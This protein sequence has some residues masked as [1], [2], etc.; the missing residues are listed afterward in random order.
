MCVNLEAGRDT[1]EGKDCVLEGGFL[2]VSQGIVAEAK[3]GQEEQSVANDQILLV[4]RDAVVG[5][6]LQKG[7]QRGREGR[8]QLALSGARDTAGGNDHPEA[9]V[10]NKGNAVNAGKLP[11]GG[12]TKRE[13]GKAH[14][15]Q[16]GIKGV[17][18]Q[19]HRDEKRRS[20]KSKV[21][22]IARGIPRHG[23]IGPPGGVK[24]STELH[25]VQHLGFE[26][27]PKSD[28]RQ[29]VAHGFPDRARAELP[30]AGKGAANTENEE[31]EDSILPVAGQETLLLVFVV[32]VEVDIDHGLGHDPGDDP[33]ENEPVDWSVLNR[34]NMG[35]HGV[36][37]VEGR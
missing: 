21:D 2:A 19:D 20:R 30:L 29:E 12:F 33:P 23:T 27:K 7:G 8:V 13:C 5:I 31:T 1:P 26:G 34:Q 36:V 3:T 35:R 24:G 25:V 9:R 32:G 15:A 6:G 18:G 17:R 14:G 37:E 16:N 4:H 22:E 10:Q 11:D 28:G